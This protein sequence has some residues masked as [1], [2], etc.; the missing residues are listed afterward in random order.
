[1][2]RISDLGEQ[3]LEQDQNLP[4][5]RARRPNSILRD[6]VGVAL[7]MSAFDD[8]DLSQDQISDRMT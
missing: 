8:F 2:L 6:K 7:Q 1:L 3:L 5:N 4:A